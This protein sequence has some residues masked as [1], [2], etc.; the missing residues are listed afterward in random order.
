MKKEV[1]AL[2]AAVS[3]AA[4][5]SALADGSPPPSASHPASPPIAA[6]DMVATLQ[7][8]CLPVLHGADVK[9]SA[10]AAGF[11][12]KDGQW[13]LGIDSDRRIELSPPDEAN[14]HICTATI[15]ARP[16]STP[17]LQR[18]LNAWA[19]AQTPPL[20]QVGQSRA[21]AAPGWASTSWRGQTPSGTLGIALGQ[22]QPGQGEPV[23][24]SDLQVSLTPA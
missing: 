9:A 11:R 4:A 18:A 23:A 21:S 17:A 13:V 3:L 22:Q 10:S 8:V 16:S 20:T 12:L 24:E 7:R 15:Y 5:A 2:V 19:V 14:P 1:S 6:T